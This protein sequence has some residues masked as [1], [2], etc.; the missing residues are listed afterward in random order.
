MKNLFGDN[1]QANILSVLRKSSTLNIETLAE[2]FGVSERT[3]RNDIKDINKVKM[4]KDYTGKYCPQVIIDRDGNLTKFKNRIN[5]FKSEDLTPFV[6]KII[7][8]SLN[9]R[10]SAGTSSI[11]S[12]FSVTVIL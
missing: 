12:T 7:C 2:R 9:V 1:R 4:H 10:K 11:I 6:I 8:D 5:K 3:V